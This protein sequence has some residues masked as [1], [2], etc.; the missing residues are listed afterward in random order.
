ME[1]ARVMGEKMLAACR[2]LQEKHTIVGDVRG[3]GLFIG[4]E[5][6]E[7]RKTKKPAARFV[8]DLMNLAFQ[9]GLLLLPCGESTIRLAPP[10]V[11]D[12]YDLETGMEI[13]DRCITELGE[14]A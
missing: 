14:K 11:I 5:F 3:V 9:Q 8:D 13:L 10:L 7:D 12:D 6:V 4:L 2:A 1:N